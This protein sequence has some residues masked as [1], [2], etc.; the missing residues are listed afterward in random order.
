MY[1]EQESLGPQESEGGLWQVALH[2][3]LHHSFRELG[4]PSST[5][6]IEKEQHVPTD[7]S[8]TKNQQQVVCKYPVEGTDQ[9]V[10]VWANVGHGP[11][12][13]CLAASAAPCTHSDSEASH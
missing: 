3:L 12:P 4:S 7:A 13:F 9:T 10:W 8:E 2:S 5:D 1:R 6:C 11:S